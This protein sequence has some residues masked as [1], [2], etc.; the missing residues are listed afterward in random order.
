MYI[1]YCAHIHTTHTSTQNNAHT[2]THTT[3]T[4]TQKTARARAHT[5]THTHSLIHTLIHTY[6]VTTLFSYTRISLHEWFQNNIFS[7]YSVLLSKANNTR[8]KKLCKLTRQF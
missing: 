5:H 4:C 2:Y 7:M 8:V 6:L 3:P 1:K